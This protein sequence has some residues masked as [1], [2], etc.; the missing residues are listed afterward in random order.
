MVGLPPGGRVNVARDFNPWP[1]SLAAFAG[2]VRWL[3]SLAAFPGCIRW[4][5]SLAAFPGCL[6][7]YFFG[8]NITCR[9][10]ITAGPG[11]VFGLTMSVCRPAF[12]IVI[13]PTSR[14]SKF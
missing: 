11:L 6:D 14:A 4:L 10:S 12:S 1:R 3:R 9:R 7:V 2:R 5:R 8:L 13:V